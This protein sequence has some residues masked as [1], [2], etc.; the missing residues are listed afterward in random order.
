[1][2]AADS[3]KAILVADTGAGGAATLLTGGIYTYAETGRNGINSRST[4]S[5]FDTTTRKLKPCAVIKER[6]R[7]V[8]GAILDVGAQKTS[9]TQVVEIYLYVDG[10]DDKAVLYNAAARCYKLLHGKNI[11]EGRLHWQHAVVNERDES[12]NMA[13]MCRFDFTLFG[14]QT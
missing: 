1:M 2:S 6:A 8:D 10:D 11:T 12:L 7:I 5:A 13:H 4:P 3:V 9:Y 14:I